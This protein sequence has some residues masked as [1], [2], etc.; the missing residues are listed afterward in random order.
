[1]QIAGAVVDD[2]DDAHGILKCALGRW[3]AL[4]LTG[5][6][7]DRAAKRASNP[8]EARFGDVM[9]VRAI[10]GFDVQRDPGVAGEGLE[11]LAHELRI[12]TT[13]LLGRKFG[14]EDKERPAGH[15]ERNP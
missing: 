2:S 15:V 3:H 12:E 6:N 10:D 8:L 4:G 7:R 14:P 11:E 5:I 1:M 9:A 13:D